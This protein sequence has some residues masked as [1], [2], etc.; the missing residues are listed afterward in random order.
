MQL[1][2]LLL[3]AWLTLVRSVFAAVLFVYNR[4]TSDRELM[5]MAAASLGPAKLARPALLV[6]VLT[7][8]AGYCAT[9]AAWLP[10]G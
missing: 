7:V 4:L 10:H 3:P 8:V 6:G 9:M 1:T 2:V 5:V